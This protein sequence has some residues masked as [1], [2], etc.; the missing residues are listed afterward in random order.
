MMLRFRYGNVND[1]Y[2][3]QDN[4]LSNKDAHPQ[5]NELFRKFLINSL[6]CA[7]LMNSALD[8]DR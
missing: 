5:G 4:Q 6:V 7:I 8:M 3:Y 2:E 1:E